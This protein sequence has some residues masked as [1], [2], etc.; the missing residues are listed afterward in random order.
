[1]SRAEAKSRREGSTVLLRTPTGLTLLAA[2][3]SG[4]LRFL[5][6]K[7]TASLGQGVGES[8]VSLEQPLAF[9]PGPACAAA[10]LLF[11]YLFI[12]SFF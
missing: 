10:F 7:V 4:A 12:Y 8:N 9:A 1:M 6:E 5:R 2:G 3:L 11:I